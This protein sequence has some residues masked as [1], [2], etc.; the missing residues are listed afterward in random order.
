MDSGT[1]L[2][3]D[4]GLGDEAVPAALPREDVLRLAI[5]ALANTVLTRVGS[6][7]VFGADFGNRNPLSNYRPAL[8][9][10]S[11]SPP[12]SGSRGVDMK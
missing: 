3:A 2:S 8:V 9:D 12:V 10:A 7:L 4:C 1:I 5:G 11:R 6:S